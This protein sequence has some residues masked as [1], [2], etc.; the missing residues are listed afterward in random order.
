MKELEKKLIAY[1]NTIISDRCEWE[2][3]NKVL[4]DL[5]EFGF[6]RDELIEMSFDADAIDIAIENNKEEK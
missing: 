5:V 6:T 3:P 4:Q 2:G 1:A